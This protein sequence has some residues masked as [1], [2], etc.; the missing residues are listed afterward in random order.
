M[1]EFF[2]SVDWQTIIHYS[3]HLLAPFAIAWIFFRKRWKE[4]G[5]I[6]FLT[7]AIDLDHLVANPIFDPQRC[8][9][10]FHPLHTYSAILVYFIGLFYQKT[11]WLAIGLLLH[12]STDLLDCYMTFRNCHEC[13]LNSSLR[14]LPFNL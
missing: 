9:I 1:K 14:D 13:F 10:N 12:I 4:A 11:R 8:S 3:G 6:M 5:I 2:L 7:L